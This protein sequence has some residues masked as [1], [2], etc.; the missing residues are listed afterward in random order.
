MSESEATLA[1]IRRSSFVK[2]KKTKTANDHV[3]STGF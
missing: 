2:N 1:V 3:V